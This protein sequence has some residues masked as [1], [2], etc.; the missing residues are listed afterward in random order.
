MNIN[1]VEIELLYYQTLRL[2]NDLEQHSW[3]RQMRR[4]DSIMVADTIKE[5]NNIANK[6]YTVTHQ[7]VKDGQ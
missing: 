1:I 3:C 2:K 5:L 7:D 6:L 4:Y